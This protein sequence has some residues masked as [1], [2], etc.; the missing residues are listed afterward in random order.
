MFQFTKAHIGKHIETMGKIYE[1]YAVNVNG[2]HAFGFPIT[3]ENPFDEKGS[4][5]NPKTFFAVDFEDGTISFVDRP[6]GRPS[7][8]TTKKVSLTLSDELWEKIEELKQET[9]EKQ[10][11]LLR[12]IVERDLTPYSYEPDKEMY[13]EFRDFVFNSEKPLYYHFYQ[14]GMFI[15]TKV[16]AVEPYYGD[17]GI[18]FTFEGGN[19]HHWADHKVVKVPRPS[20]LLNAN[21][22]VCYSLFSEY[23]EHIGYIYTKKD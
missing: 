18:K 11:A 14:H 4:C 23:G 20:N 9:G 17:A 10:S 22:E 1:V 19:I 8:G 21:C 5:K 7:L 12:S 16:T 3:E 15:L 2:E 6:I 13:Q